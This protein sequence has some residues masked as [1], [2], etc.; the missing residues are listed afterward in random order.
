[1]PSHY[2][3][4][5]NSVADTMSVINREHRYEA[6]NDSWCSMVGKPREDALGHHLAEVWGETRYSNFI[7]PQLNRVFAE[8]TPLTH[9]APVD[10]PTHGVRECSITYYPGIDRHG[11]VAFAVVLTRDISELEQTRRALLAAKE[12]AESASR[13]KSEF[14]ASM[15]HELRTPLNAILG[16][17]QLLAQDST[18][19]HTQ[20]DN[21]Q[22]IERAGRHLLTLV[23]DLLDLSRIESGKILDYHPAPV[24]VKSV[25]SD[26]L[27]MVAPLALKRAI[28]LLDDIPL[29]SHTTAYCDHARLRQVLIN[30]LS[31]AIKYN[32]PGGQVILRSEEAGKM[33]RISVSDNGEGIPEKLQARIFT[34]FD[35]LRENSSTSEG[36]G[37]G[38]VITRKIIQA[39]GGNIG[40]HSTEGKGST[41]WIEIP[42]G[43][44]FEFPGQA[45][46]PAFVPAEQKQQHSACPI[47]PSH[48]TSGKR[49]LIA[50]DNPINQKLAQAMLGRLGYTVDVVDT[51][52]KALAAA[53][54]GEYA[55]V[56]M[57]CQM[58][59]MDG[60]EASSAIRLA[61]K[62]SQIHLPIIAM[63]ANAM[64]ADLQRCLDSGMD[65]YL[66]KPVD[67][68]KL[69]S[70]VHKW[71]TESNKDSH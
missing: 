24:N 13:A 45:A 35:R 32:R 56:L 60:Y 50:E 2:E 54:S 40:F 8:G 41:F 36:T 18:L 61:E 63:T 58:P 38:L 19:N 55:L 22:E 1:M 47:E 42:A 46:V 39:M 71:L 68:H 66:V 3:F 37:I 70:T 52:E 57:D 28:N 67:I 33:L 4:I 5:V 25:V 30:L 23:S 34:A 12:A 62:S 48:I 27:A 7:A 14:L 11:K 64:Q 44:P 9:Q 6:V 20:R 17:S 43:P 15:S 21:A 26:S 51:G 53:L 16:F 59:I 29:D 49:L 65:D 69:A 10:Y 31:N